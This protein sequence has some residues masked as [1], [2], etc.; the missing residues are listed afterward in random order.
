MIASIN[1]T[2]KK[3]I[4]V[5]STFE[6]VSRA[7]KLAEEGALVSLLVG[8]T[9]QYRTGPRAAIEVFRHARLRSRYF[10]NAF[11]VV[12]TDRNKKTN[13]QLHRW[14]LRYGFLLN[15][16]D[17]KESCNF[18]HLATRRITPSLEIAVLTNGASPAFASR[19]ANRISNQISKDDIAV[20]EAFVS[21]RVQLKDKGLSTFDFNWD[22]LERRV[23]GETIQGEGRAHKRQDVSHG[24]LLLSGGSG[25]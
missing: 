14:S 22:V 7:T 9:E 4:V 20:F 1:L 5:G 23:R 21:T 11:L 15:T 25:G 10:K 18:Y 3:V 6:A 13:E 24:R 2:G 17:E 16:L 8:L 19:L 12:A